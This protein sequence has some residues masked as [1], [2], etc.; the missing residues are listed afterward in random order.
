MSRYSIL[1]DVNKCNGCYNCFLSCRDEYYGNDYLRI[2]C[3][4]TPEWSVLDAGAGGRA[5]CLSKTQ[6]LLYPETMH[7]LR[8]RSLHRLL[9]K[10]AQCIAEMMVL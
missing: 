8:I 3:S 1:I 9:Q 5:R 7:A 4:T 10:T 2:F 6:G